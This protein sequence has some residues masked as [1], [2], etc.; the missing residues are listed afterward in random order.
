MVGAPYQTT[1]DFHGKFNWGLAC[2]LRTCSQCNMDHYFKYCTETAIY[3]LKKKYKGL[4]SK[5]WN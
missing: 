5:I 1:V 2:L 3:V 4:V